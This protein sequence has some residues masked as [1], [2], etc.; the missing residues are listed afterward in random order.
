MIWHLSPHTSVGMAT[1]VQQRSI[2]MAVNQR[3]GLSFDFIER[4][5][6]ELPP[7]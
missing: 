2:L 7:V 4:E 1:T 6:S 3:T 5:R